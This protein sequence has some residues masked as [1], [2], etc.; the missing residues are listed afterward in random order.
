MVAD[1]YSLCARRLQGQ[2]RHDRRLTRYPARRVV[3]LV[4]GRVLPALALLGAASNAVAFLVTQ[5][6]AYGQAA[7]L[8][9]GYLAAL[10]VLTVLTQLIAGP[11]AGVDYR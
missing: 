5:N 11:V 8:V 1:Y 6:V 9:P 3:R 4:V 10:V 7:L 2:R